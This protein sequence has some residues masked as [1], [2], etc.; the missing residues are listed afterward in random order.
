MAESAVFSFSPSRGWSVPDFPVLDSTRTLVVVFGAT[1]FA[2]AP[3]PLERLFEAYPRS[4]VIGCS[5]AGE[6]HGTEVTD[7]GLAVGVIRFDRTR[8]AL[9][10]ADVDTPPASFAVGESIGARLAAP[11][12]RAVVVLADGLRVD[13]AELLRGLTS[14]V[15]AGVA[16]TGGLAADGDRFKNAWVLRAGRLRSGAVAVGLFGDSVQMSLGAG[17]GAEPSGPEWLVTRSEGNVVFELDGR[18]ALEIYA[19]CVGGDAAELPV[20]GLRFPLAVRASATDDRRAVRTVVA[21]DEAERSI[22]LAGGVSVGHRVQLVRATVDRL[23]AGAAAAGRFC[24]T[25]DAPSPG[26]S[27]AIAISGLGRR[28]VLGQRAGDELSASL[29][30]LPRGTQPIGF[31][32][33]GEIAPVGSGPSDLRSQSFALTLLHESA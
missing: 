19:Q 31:Y 3:E 20:T 17:E 14:R 24:A 27:L 5:S 6:I 22:V 9:V 26:G 16:V 32:G 12:L 18:P 2:D 21:V 4:R 10:G 7:D 29:A 30:A 33:Y 23:L 28:L 11:D 13:G 8:L 25:G 15:P 1:A